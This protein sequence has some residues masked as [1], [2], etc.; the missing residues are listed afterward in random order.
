MQ[1]EEPLSVQTREK[2]AQ[3][4]KTISNS[5]IQK[6]QV[7]HFLWYNL[8]PFIGTIAA[9]ISLRW[10][11]IGIVEIALVLTFWA[12]TMTGVSVGFHRYFA[13]RAFKTHQA[14]RVIFAI[15]GSM[16]AQGPLIS[17]VAVHRRH[18][19]F[20]D[21]IGDPHSPNLHGEGIFGIIKGLWHSHVGWLIAHEYPNPAYYAPELLRDQTLAKVNRQYV[22]W[23]VLSLA[24][25]TI[26]GGLLHYSWIGALQGLLWGGFVRIFLVDNVILSVNSLSHVYGTHPFDTKDNSRN[27]PWI[28]LP[29]FGE[30]WQN[31]HHAFASSASIGLQW[32]QV[33]FGYWM[34]WLL[35]KL[36][37]AWDIN[38]P[39]A[40]MMAAK[41][42]K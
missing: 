11:P 12:L 40:E 34:V 22:W 19:E 24:I 9:L 13:H 25:P 26:L 33:D 31:N 27:N 21:E 15:L 35:G 1:I 6:L 14:M 4:Q 28:A 8:L 42:L 20:S 32:W 10:L 30:S 2:V 18:H 38:L 16:A 36:G 3:K 41:T 29:T 37:L 7:K 17:W 39:S 5:Y 23:I